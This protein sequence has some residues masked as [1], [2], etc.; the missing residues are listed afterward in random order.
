MIVSAIVGAAASAAGAIGGA[1][2]AKKARQ[3]LENRRI[4]NEAWYNRRMNEDATQKADAQRLLQRTEDAIRERNKSMAGTQAV[5][6]GTEESVS[7]AKAANTAAMADTASQIAAAGANRKDSIEQT[8][9]QRKDNIQAAQDEM[10][11][12]EAQNFAQAIQGVGS[13]VGSIADAAIGSAGSSAS[14]TP[15]TTKKTK[16]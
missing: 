7:A 3:S 14:K 8:Y 11:A 12:Q 5:M 15:K 9:L 13:A 6:G 2:K 1:M 10:N 16:V 4:D